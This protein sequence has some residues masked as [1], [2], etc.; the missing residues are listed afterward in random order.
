[1]SAGAGL[2]LQDAKGNAIILNSADMAAANLGLNTVGT[3]KDNSALFQ[4]G[5]NETQT[6]S[7]TIR[8][9][10]AIDLG[11][12]ATYGDSNVG[13]T[14]FA[15]LSELTTSGASLAGVLKNGTADQKAQA[16]GL[17]DKAIDDVTGV[18]GA[19]GA[20]QADN[21]QVQLD[22][23]RVAYE[24]LQASES[25]IRDADMTREMAEFTKNSIMMQAG[26][27]MLAQANQ[28]PNQLLSLLK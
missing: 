16:I 6:V 23:L 26:T 28:Q 1:M 11:K 22:S 27:A 8:S 5:A 3:V 4:I 2:T 19:L 7:V 14:A 17:I 12:F 15:N 9:T 13:V 10:K 20:V 21:L 25:T 24:N 18:R